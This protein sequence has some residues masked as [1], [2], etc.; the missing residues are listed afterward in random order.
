MFKLFSESSAAFQLLFSVFITLV[1]FL[2]VFIIGFAIAIPI[3]QINVAEYSSYFNVEYPENLNIIKYFQALQ[4]IALFILPAFAI[5]YFFKK[6]NDDY[7]SLSVFPSLSVM[8]FVFITIVVSLPAV[9]VLIEFNQNMKFPESLSGIESWMKASEEQAQKITE[10]LVSSKEI[11][12]LLLN[13]FILAILPALGEELLFRGVF[14]KL[15]IKITKNHHWGIFITAFIF[16]AMHFQFYGFLPRL[17]LG[18]YLGYLLVW[19]K[20]IWLPIVAH[21]INN[22][23]AVIFYF[24]FM[25]SEEKFNPDS[26]G[27][28]NYLVS[29]FSVF[30][31]AFLIY[32]TRLNAKEG[33]A[34]FYS[35]K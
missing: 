3:F 33:D 27:T 17:L 11:Q 35:K 6:E 22:A 26:F 7:L 28:E 24:F 5:A 30:M 13:I 31:I 21:F 29:I 18:V 4:T 23:M 16:S 9:N 15:F 25:N 14:Q 32:F 1:I 8:F 2:A 12:G 10:A 20:S 34:L 19:S